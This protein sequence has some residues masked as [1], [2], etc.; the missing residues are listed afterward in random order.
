MQKVGLVLVLSGRFNF[1]LPLLDCLRRW[2]FLDKPRERR[3]T[4]SFF[5]RR[6]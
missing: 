1:S 5:E 3:E 2:G 4:E 6:A